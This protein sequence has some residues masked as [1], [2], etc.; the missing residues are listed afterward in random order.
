MD[1]ACGHQS[2]GE[3]VARTLLCKSVECTLSKFTNAMKLEGVADSPEGRAAIQR[4]L[5]RPER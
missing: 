5:N 3:A 4:D 1:L 2:R